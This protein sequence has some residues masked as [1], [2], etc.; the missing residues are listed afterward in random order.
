[1]RMTMPWRVFSLGLLLLGGPLT[2]ESTAQDS[3]AAAPAASA[4]SS[5]DLAKQSQNP[6]G[7]LISLPFQNNTGFG[8]GPDDDVQ[9]TLNIQPVVPVSLSKNW[10]LINRVILPI[11]YLPEIVPGQGS[12]FGLGDTSYTGFVSPK[13]P[14]SLIWGAGPTFSIPT[15]TDDNLGSDQWAVGPSVVLLKMPGPWVIGA[16]VSNVWSIDSNDDDGDVNFMFSQLFLNYNKPS[17][18]FYSTA[19][20]ITA[21]WEAE[22]GER[23]TIPIGGGIGKVFKIGKQPV[24]ALGQVYYN[25]EKPEFA[26]DWTVRLQFVLLFPK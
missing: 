25:V 12:T 14:G 18:W 26:A 1:M 7:N 5:Q 2:S 6:V 23:W 10:N 22:S 21:N 8:F 9:N 19:P 15:A 3:G 11:T 20:A 13:N 24:S 17:G 16:L 4:S